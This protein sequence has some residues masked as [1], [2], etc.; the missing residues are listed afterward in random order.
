MRISRRIGAPA[1]EVWLLLVDTRTW[2]RWGPSIRAVES[3][4]IVIGAATR[5]RVQVLGGVWLPFEVTQWVPGR[6][7]AWKV[8][9]IEATGHRVNP[10]DERN[11]RLSFEV[12]LWA[13]PYLIVCWWAVKRINKLVAANRIGEA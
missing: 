11:C 5:G 12:P 1:A 10:V 3:D 8:G 13:A 6:Y 9:G 2:T 4:E 7:W